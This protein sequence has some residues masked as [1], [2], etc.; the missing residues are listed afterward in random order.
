MAMQSETAE[1]VKANGRKGRAKKKATVA[2]DSA[3]D[4]VDRRRDVE[5]RLRHAEILLSVS[6]RCASIESLDD[7]L[8]TLVEMT[9]WELGCERGTLFLNDPQTG[10][11]YSRVAQGTFR[12][13]I[14]ILNTSGIAGHVFTSGKGVIIQDAYSDERFNRAIDQQTGFTT[15]SVLCV[16]IRT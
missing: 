11:L 15:K 13:E 16:P 2:P 4:A 5:A 14:R 1:N 8:E 10:E 3:G 9:S 12:R 6:K 7:I